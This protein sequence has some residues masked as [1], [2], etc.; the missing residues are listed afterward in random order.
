M[1]KKLFCK[2]LSIHPDPELKE[3]V[4]IHRT[5]R[6][7]MAKDGFND[8]VKLDNKW[9]KTELPTDS[10]LTARE[11]ID[12]HCEMIEIEDYETEERTEVRTDKKSK[13]RFPIYRKRA[14]TKP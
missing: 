3:Y 5:D 13:E 8:Y 14:I 12:H 11:Y 6:V 4:L 2:D 9:V 10:T 7:V 1:V